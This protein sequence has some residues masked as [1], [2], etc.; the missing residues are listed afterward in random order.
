MIKIHISTALFSGGQLHR[1]IPI[2]ESSEYNITIKTYD[3]H[4]THSRRNALHPRL[5]GKIPKML[6]WLQ[7]GDADYYIWM[8]APFVIT[9]KKIGEIVTSCMIGYDMCLFLHPWNKNI[10]D[11]VNQVVR[12][13]KN[14]CDYLF[15]RY[16]G[17]PIMEQYEHYMADDTFTDDK[18]FSCGLFIY[19]RSLVS[20]PR[21]NL[22]IDW[23]LQNAYWSVE[24][25]ISLPYLLH[26]WKTKYT[27]YDGCIYNN[28]LATYTQ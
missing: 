22:M 11:E 6:E 28:E 1:F 4:N 15:P 27:T 23:F 19:S 17:E 20:N 3:D 24:D 9:S 21:S 16:D 10:Q 14:N 7:Y 25:Q 5:K 8:D 18:L 13:V 12:G 26:K 2:Q